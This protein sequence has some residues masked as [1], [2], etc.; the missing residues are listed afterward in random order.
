MPSF[1]ISSNAVIEW[2]VWMTLAISAFLITYEFDRPVEGYLYGATGWP[3]FIIVAI[4][5]GA[6][7][8]FLFKIMN[9]TSE[10]DVIHYIVE[11]DTSR[12]NLLKILRTLGIFAVPLIFLWFLPRAGFY[13]TTPIFIVTYMLILGVKSWK[14]LLIVPCI[15]HGLVLF[16]FTRVFYVA[17]PVGNWDLFYD[18][19]NTIISLVRA[20]L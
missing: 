14:P 16:F 2:A 5:V 8:Q 15:V 20:G 4:M 3:R 13:L 18:W 10:K 1:K 9:I 6:T 7:L 19:N 17:L 11:F 12:A